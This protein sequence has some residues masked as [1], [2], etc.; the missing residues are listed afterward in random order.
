MA[1][2]KRGKKAAPTAE[3][4]NIRPPEL[5]EAVAALRERESRLTA[6]LETA[7]DAIITID[8][9]GAIESVNRA[10]ER[11]FGYCA[12]EL[13]GQNVKMLMLSPYAEE[14][15]KYLSNYLKT[16]VKKIIGIGREAVARR[17]DG[18]LFPVSLAISEVDHLK[19]FTAILR[20]ISE[21]KR[22][23]HEIVQIALLE[24]QRLGADLHDECGQELTALG[25]LADSLV[26]SLKERA[27]AEVEV[28]GKVRDGLKHVLQY[29]RD[30]ARGLS[31]A[32]IDPAELAGALEELASRLSEISGI[33]CVF[34]GDTTAAVEDS[35]VATHLYRIAQEACTNA[36]K[37]AQA[38]TVQVHLGAGR[39]VV[40]LRIRDDGIGVSDR[41][42]NGLGLRIMR[43]RASVIGADLTIEPGKRRGTV[44]T[45][46]L[47]RERRHGPR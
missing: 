45:C 46:T 24:Q 35:V 14:H 28:A 15:D 31:K 34:H 9:R 6:I 3:G 12:N 21:R 32:E 5:I 2:K 44:V 17:K 1:A 11:M 4:G 38:R 27:P 43:N 20:D 13:I 39:G 7:A 23:E 40:T 26:V 36:L 30:V 33:S 47:P 16:G 8:K 37:H 25:L 22:L 41:A 18:S 42:K 29:L 10:T 19:M